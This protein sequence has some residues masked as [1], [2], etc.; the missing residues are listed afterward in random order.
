MHYDD[1]IVNSFTNIISREMRGT[2]SFCGKSHL[3]VSENGHSSIYAISLDFLFFFAAPCGMGDL[4]P[5]P[6]IKST[7]PVSEV[8]SLNHWTGQGSPSV[9]FLTIWCC[10]FLFLKKEIT[11]Y[12]FIWPYL[13]A[14]GILVPPIGIKPGTP[15]VKAGNLAI[16]PEWWQSV[17]L[18]LECRKIPVSALTHRSEPVA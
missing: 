12:L 15:T 18:P 10:Y 8:R 17:F 3:L 9:D 2:S 11:F 6:G 7:P 16:C 1:W 13:M 5:G 4:V 14:W